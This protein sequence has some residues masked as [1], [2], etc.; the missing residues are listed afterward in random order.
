MKKIL[1]N[2]FEKY[3]ENQ[4]FLFGVL[5]TLLGSYLA[6]YFGARL[7]GALDLHF[8][9]GIELKQ[10]FLDNAINIPTLVIFLYIAALSIN[11]KTRII[12]IMNTVLVSR[13]ILCIIP[14]FNIGGLM[15]TP[16]EDPMSMSTPEMAIQIIFAIILIAFIIWFIALL[17]NGFK[18]ATNL[19]T[20]KHKIIFAV[21]ILA[22]EIL[23]KYIIITLNY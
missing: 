14:L 9:D 5:I 13:T 6:Y 8:S 22:A 17:Y 3:N 19:K 12:D 10:P 1:L 21:A 16:G 20:T 23:S 18:V 7:D 11:K 2:P 15:Y 4:L